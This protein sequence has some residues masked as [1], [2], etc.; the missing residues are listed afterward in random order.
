VAKFVLPVVLV[1]NPTGKVL[2]SL[3]G[4]CA[5][6]EGTQ[7]CVMPTNSQVSIIDAAHVP[8]EG[9]VMDSL[10]IRNWL[11]PRRRKVVFWI[12]GL[13]LFY[14]LLGFLILPPIVRSVAIKQLSRQL[15]REVTI[16]KIQIN[17]FAL[18]TTVRGLLIK[19]KDGQ[20]FISWDEVYANFQLSSFFGPAWTFREIRVIKPFVHAQVNAD[21]TFNFSDLITK[22]ATN[23]AAAKTEPSKPLV[24]RVDRLHIRGAKAALA[25]FSPREPFKRTVGPLDITLDN[26]RT[27]P[28]NQNPYAFTGTTD[29]G[30]RIA[31]SGVFYL[32][33]LRSTGEL[34][35][36]NFTLNKYAPLYQD[37]VRF[38]IRDGTLALDVK[39]RLEFSASNRVAAV[40]DAAFAL[41]DFKLGQPGDSN[42][43]AELTLF[44]VTGASADFQARTANIGAVKMEDGKFSVRR[45]KDNSVNVVE[46]AKP[47]AG[48]N[49]APTGILF[50]L[51]SMTNAVAML[52]DS[53]NQWRGSV[54]SVAVTHCALHLED[55]ANTRPARLDLSDI[56]FTAKN[57][58]N[59]PGTNLTA[60]LALRWNTNGAIKTAVTASFQPTTADVQVDLDRL[61]LS[62]LDAYLE[63]KLDLYILGSQVN[64]HGLVQLRTEPDQL[65]TVT[66]RG[67]ASLDDFYTVDGTFGE[68]LLKWDTLR[69]SGM[70]ANLNPPSVA[71]RQID[72]V[73]AYA[74][75]I[76]ET[77]QTI[78]LLNVLRLTPTNAPATNETEIASTAKSSATNA[79]LPQVTLGAIVFSNTAVRFTDRSLK[80]EVNLALRDLNGLVAGLSTRQLQHADIAL[81]AKI[82]GVGPATITGTINPF[83]GTQTNDLKISVKDMDLTPASPYAG[84]FAGYRIA[85][86][87]L[88][89][90]LAYELTGKK[91][92][93]KNVITLDHF[94]FGEKVDSPNATHLPV[95]L[96]IAILKDRDGMI[97]LDVPIEGSLD[98]P[99]FRIGRVVTRAIL[100]IL[101]KVATSPFSL[102]GAVFG[103]G[104]E[105]LGWQEFAPG[106]AELSAADITKLDSLQK[107]LYA[108]PALQLEIAGAIDPDS[109]REGLRH[110]ALEKQ[111][112]ERQWQKLNQVERAT[113]AVDQLVLTPEAH[114]QWVKQLYDEAL[115][116]GKINTPSIVAD[117]NL[118]T[119]APVPPKPVTMKKGAAQLRLSPF[120][121]KNTAPVSTTGPK[122]IPPQ[123]TMETVLLATFPVTDEDLEALASAR[124]KAVRDYLAGTGKVETGRL[125]LKSGNADNLRRDGSRVWLQL[126]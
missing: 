26:F 10:K 85:E 55:L 68:D 60:E 82:D 100:N 13:P 72:V 70:D 88:N 124:A 95:R 4:N 41:R 20:P 12:L 21:G 53:T 30:E 126:R 28:D 64:L 19:E 75:L 47:A 101:E 48:A 11:S 92:N 73:N 66:F 8:S 36:Y 24:L 120:I 105:E 52:L 109:D 104:S 22:F 25:D 63:R 99:K 117:T 38:E 57:I 116:G 23:N 69:F 67:D 18:S 45:E 108:R 56:T 6:I 84:K 2:K 106:S 54:G 112:R 62:T 77:N 37:L 103:G 15:G 107:A 65:P 49:N 7:S 34:K 102:I 115:A 80:P 119:T 121:T 9:K 97:V 16:E 89:L 39:Y 44:S 81:N 90:D 79:P 94:T 59:L 98:D 96:A 125:F 123:D 17:P 83:S 71:I 58:S 35:L 43:L 1:T 74:R 78:N 110:R 118:T 27:N 32:T 111:V 14:T 93:S 122:P 46:L 91:L 40:D 5:N 3:S 86:G 31:W 33:P 113:N 76:I 87:K 50:L 51:R 42:N 61:D 114:A 29:A